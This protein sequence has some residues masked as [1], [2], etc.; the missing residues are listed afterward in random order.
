M[1]A[2]QTQTDDEPNE[3]AALDTLDMLAAF[4]CQKYGEAALRETFPTT[5]FYREP[6]EKAADILAAKGLTHVASIMADIASGCP[7]EIE[8]CGGYPPGSFNAEYWRRNW[9]RKQWQASPEFEKH[10][11][12]Q[13]SKIT[14]KP[15][16][17]RH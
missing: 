5:D 14:P 12:A 9:L 6:L 3:F 16:P 10:L 8:S 2:P 11:R 7:S 1:N 13:K 4:V 15:K 17:Y